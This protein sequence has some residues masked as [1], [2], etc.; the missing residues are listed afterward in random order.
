[1]PEKTGVFLGTLG[2]QKS[3][4]LMGG[5]SNV[6]YSPPGYLIFVRDGTFLA[7]AFD[8]GGLQLA[9]R[10]VPL[11]THGGERSPAAGVGLRTVFRFPERHPRVCGY[12]VRQASADLVRP[13]R[14]GAR[15]DWR[16]G[17]VWHRHVVAR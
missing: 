2:T 6:I 15:Y 13:E 8:L 11:P 17:R 9:N 14:Q 5:E 7:Q 3:R 12:R 1:M 10:A 16:A 4:L